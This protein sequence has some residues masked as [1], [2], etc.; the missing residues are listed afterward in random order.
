MLMRTAFLLFC[1]LLPLLA[2]SGQEPS[3]AAGET[4]VYRVEVDLVQLSVA[5]T[6]SQGR[7]IRGLLPGDFRVLEDGIPQKIALFSEAGNG[8]FPAGATASN[9]FILLDTSNMMYRSFVYAQDAIGDF[10]RRLDK[11]DSIAVYGFSRNLLRVSPL[12]SDHRRALIGLHEVVAGDDAAIYNALLLTLQDA[13]RVRGR[14]AIVVFSNGPD[15]GSM[16]SPETVGELAES[17]GVPIYIISTRD[18][19]RDPI[20]ARAF[21]RLASRTG[22]TAYFAGAWQ[23][24]AEAFAA[25]RDDLGHLYSVAYYPAGNTNPGWRAIK[26]ELTSDVARRYR[27]RTRSGYRARPASAALESNRTAAPQSGSGPE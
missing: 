3:P 6:D 20:S 24:Q 4:P 5:V 19:A 25:I 8:Q 18:A 10:I 16:A 22:G 13:A 2:A 15:T 12:A 11:D 26:V 7:Y 23:K 9:V 27:L 1:V 21:E 14:K 17:Q